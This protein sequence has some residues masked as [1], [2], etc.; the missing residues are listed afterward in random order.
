MSTVK[1]MFKGLPQ[2]VIISWRPV[3]RLPLRSIWRDMTHATLQQITYASSAAPETLSCQISLSSQDARDSHRL[4]LPPKELHEKAS[5]QCNHEGLLHICNTTSAPIAAL[6]QSLVHRCRK[7][8]DAPSKRRFFHGQDHSLSYEGSSNK[9]QLSPCAANLLP[10]PNLRHARNKTRPAS[11]PCELRFKPRNGIDCIS[12]A[13]KLQ[14]SANAGLNC[15]GRLDCN[16]DGFRSAS[17]CISLV[18][19]VVVAIWTVPPRNS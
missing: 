2:A 14:D 18:V 1:P 15:G 13:S 11:F 8:H 4:D 12:A 17:S 7:G 5:H 9:L 6:R 3:K 19:V 16:T 10:R